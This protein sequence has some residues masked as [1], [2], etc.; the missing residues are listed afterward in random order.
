MRRKTTGILFLCI[1]L[2]VTRSF[3]CTAQMLTQGYSFYKPSNKIDRKVRES[4]S[5][6]NANPLLLDYDVKFYKLDI[7]ADNRS[8]QIHG[9]VTILAWTP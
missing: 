5:T 7:E 9:N 1:L 8:N 4:V 2:L 6:M 3:T